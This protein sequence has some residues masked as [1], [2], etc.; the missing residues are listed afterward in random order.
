[1]RKPLILLA[2]TL[3][4]FIV[5][6][7]ILIVNVALPALMQ[8]LGASTSELQWI[9]DAYSLAF[10]ALV[11]AGGSF[12]DR[13]GRKT[14]LMVGLV[15][16]AASCLWAAVIDTPGQLVAAR[17][18]MGVGAALMFPATLSIL[19]N[20]FT[21][22]GER[23]GAIGLWGTVT[24]FGVAT[25]PIVGGALLAN[26]WWGSIFVFMAA[27][28]VV[29]GV[30]IC[31]VVPNSRAS[32]T[33]PIDWL[34][35]GLS[36]AGVAIVVLGVIEA[37][38]WGWGSARTIFSLTLGA[39]LLLAFVAVERRSAHPML[40]VS[41]FANPRFSAASAAVAI[42][43]FALQGFI[44]VITQYLQL[45]KYY[46][47]FSMGVRLL[48]MAFAVAISSIVGTKLA[49]KI[50]NKVVVVAGLVL[51]SIGLLWC[52]TNTGATSYTMIAGEMLLLGIGVGL[53]SAPATEAIMG[54]VPE[55][56]AGVGAAVNDATRLFGGTLGVAVI[57][58]VASSLYQNRL[59]STL[60][61][62][63][64]AE[65]AF[66]AAS[67]SFGAAIQVSQ[68]LAERGL[69]EPGQRLLDGATSAYLHGMS[70]GS[71][72]AAG[73]SLVGALLA[74]VLLP[75]RP[76]DADRDLPPEL[77]ARDMS[78]AAAGA[79]IADAFSKRLQRSRSK[80]AANSPAGEGFSS[81]IGSTAATVVGDGTEAD[82]ERL[83]DDA[84]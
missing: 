77:L 33:P 22:R 37:P 13:W 57:G 73:V 17:A 6:V 7:E 70:G 53:A 38:G 83:R 12:G 71:L 61:A 19:V 65:D 51:F 81:P 43:F 18:A 10:A 68:M 58:S 45:V 63:P 47:P 55:D 79:L 36:S 30:L 25:G 62:V 84:L 26:H 44:F 66:A 28:A 60:P 4:A 23:A 31:W 75:A 52:S 11:L 14:V 78:G 20:V 27:L 39:A 8:E 2:L 54:A 5:S 80:N 9:V 64:G 76:K 41:L 40:D 35:L 32:E 56:K 46:S 72:V 34:G 15:I 59:E 1:M 67:N 49:V 82:G 21:E 74:A 42:S 69:A 50:G 3:T 48:P 29:V 16:F 24:G